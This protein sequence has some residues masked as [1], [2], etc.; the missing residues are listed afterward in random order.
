MI[1]HAKHLYRFV[2]VSSRSAGGQPE[3]VNDTKSCI[4]KMVL[5]CALMVETCGL[6]DLAVSIYAN[7]RPYADD[8]M[9]V[10]LLDINTIMLPALMVGTISHF[11]HG[12]R[13][14][15]LYRGCITSIVMKKPWHGD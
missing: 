15:D 12:A 4:L 6:S 11:T 2:A 14:S 3:P 5:A 13:F 8:V 10:E 7:V 1:A 9:H